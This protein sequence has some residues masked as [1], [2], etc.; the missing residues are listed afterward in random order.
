[1]RLIKGL[2]NTSSTHD[3]SFN[4][5]QCSKG[6]KCKQY[7][8]HSKRLVKHDN[9]LLHVCMAVAVL[10]WW[11]QVIKET[12]AL[13]FMIAG[14]CKE[15][16][17]VITAVLVFGDK[18]GPVNGVGLVIVIG[19]VLLFNWYKLQKLKEQ[20]RQR[21]HSKDGSV[22]L[23][24][25]EEAGNGSTGGSPRRVVPDS[26]S[27]GGSRS[28]SPEIPGSS[29]LPHSFTKR[30]SGFTTPEEEQGLTTEDVLKL[31]YE[32]LLPLNGVMIR[33]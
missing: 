28:I 3:K 30:K 17:T 14:T 5:R 6:I 16:V 26:S 20:M 31:E 32:P 7:V 22:E 11:L 9:L 10:C 12:S 21:I 25:H 8:W 27:R 29:G 1:M 23:Q 4:K 15:V 19:G 18:F 24:L 2:Q 13:T 33:R